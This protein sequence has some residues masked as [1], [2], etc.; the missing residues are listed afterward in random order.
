MKGKAFIEDI[1]YGRRRSIAGE[2]ILLLLSLLYGAAVRLRLFLFRTGIFRTRNL[3]C[4]VISIGNLTIGGTGKTPAAIQI[5]GLLRDAGRHPVVVS[6]GYG[7]KNESEIIV[8][9]DGGVT[10]ESPDR[11]GD[12]SSLMGVK[13]PGVPVVV[14]ADRYRAGMFAYELFGPDT[15]VLDDGFQH[16]RLARDI[17]IVL[18]DGRV[19]F[20]N[21]RLFPAGVLRESPR[22]LRRA[23]AVVITRSDDAKDADELARIIRRTTNAEIFFACH[24]PVDLIDAVGREVKDLS[25]LRGSSVAAFC[26]I[27]RPASFASL[28]A[29]LGADI[30]TSI[31]YPDHATYSKHDLASLYQKAA[32]AR[33][34]MIVTTEKDAIKLRQY[35]P[36]GIWALR[37]EMEINERKQWEKLIL[38][39]RA[40]GMG[41]RG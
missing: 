41:R 15:V 9:S 11:V 34:T 10:V 39:Q 4:R 24:R 2:A 26:G 22:G 27:A 1:M 38:R 13:L 25:A 37:I 12:E 16:V 30:R 14:G 8:A 17:D 33:A 32:D 6:R 28:L 35:G 23:K 29:S 5:A 21:G 7:R 36:E 18:I 3:P 20:G 40:E 19:P 31:S